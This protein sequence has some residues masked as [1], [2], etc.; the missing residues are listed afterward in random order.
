VI[1]Q[2]WSRRSFLAQ[3][4]GGVSDTSI[5]FE[6]DAAN[7][8]L[9]VSSPQSNYKNS[10]PFELAIVE[11]VVSNPY[12]FFSRPWPESSRTYGGKPIT[13]GDVFSGRITTDDNDQKIP[14][15]WNLENSRMVDFAPPNSIKVFKK[16]S[17]NGG[18]GS[19]S[20]LCFPFFS[21]HLSFPVKPGETVWIMKQN[22][23]TYYW[24]CRQTSYRQIEDVNYTFSQRERN[25]REIVSPKDEGV[26]LGFDAE[27]TGKNTLNFENIIGGS[28][29]YKEEFTGEPVPRLTKDCSDFLIQGSNNSH[30]YLGKEKFEQENTVPPQVFSAATSPEETIE[31][32]KPLSPAVDICV[33]RKADEL[34]RLKSVTD[35]NNLQNTLSVETEGLSAASGRR[36]DPTL[37][38]YENEKARDRLGKEVSQDEFLDNDI[39]NCIARIYMSNSRSIDDLLNLPNYDGENSAAPGGFLRENDYGAMVALGTNTRIVGRETIKI[40]NLLGNSGIHFTPSGDVI[41]FGNRL[42]GAKIVLKAA[43]DIKIVPGPAGVIKLGS[44]EPQGGIAATETA[45]SALGAVEGT[46]IF[47]T[48]GGIIGIKGGFG[49]FGKKVLIDI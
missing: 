31:E 26:F 39:L 40:G 21:S 14:N 11:E 41:I 29:S 33:L 34:F 46:P 49:T 22:S 23:E 47:T 43:G 36:Q 4:Q 16:D 45:T 3:S 25:V 30:I 18:R 28:V 35:N 48:A 7:K 19:K 17:L 2:K 20:I 24:M 38:Y 8:A 32:R 5:S 6:R 12:D 9:E 15:S 1:S 44:D 37:R 42:G 13:V 27:V 10:S